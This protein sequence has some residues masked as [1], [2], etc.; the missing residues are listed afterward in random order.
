MN[1][2]LTKYIFPHRL[3]IYNL[4]ICNVLLPLTSLMTKIE[5]ILFPVSIACSLLVISFIC[6]RA[7]SEHESKRISKHWKMVWQR[8]QIVLIAYV[9]S[10]SIELLSGVMTL[11]QQDPQL[12]EIMLI[13]FTR[14]AIVPTLLIVTPILIAST[15]TVRKIKASYGVRLD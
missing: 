5:K 14:I 7:H 6:Y 15:L 1:D 8:C 10:I 11:T 13:A 2:D 12:R 3:L 9:I 4:L